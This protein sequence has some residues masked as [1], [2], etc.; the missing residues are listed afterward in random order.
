MYSRDYR[1]LAGGMILTILGMAFSLYA[2]LN[3]EMG[4][5]RQMGPGLFPAA[6][7]VAMAVLGAMIAVP[8]AFRQGSA[9]V[10][11][12]WSPFIT[13]VGIAAFAILIRPFGMIPAILA[14]VGLTSLAD[15]KAHPLQL[16]LLGGLLCVAAWLIFSVALHLP[17]PI[18]RWPF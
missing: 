17:I 10:V 6:L 4:T 5:I 9:I 1:D 15:P 16:A 14:V 7:G 3:L 13:L 2:L 18:L 11:K 8:A 12:L